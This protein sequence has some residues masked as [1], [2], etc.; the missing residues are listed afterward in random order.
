[1]AS[2]YSQHSATSGT[3]GTVHMAKSVRGGMHDPIVRMQ[4]NQANS[5]KPILIL[6]P[7][8]RGSKAKKEHSHSLTDSQSAFKGGVSWTTEDYIRAHKI[9][10][11][12]GQYNFEG[13]RIP[14]PTSIRYDRLR[15]ALGDSISPEDER[16]LDL[17]KFG[18]PIDCK[19]S[20]GRIAV[21]K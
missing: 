10:E 9:V 13:C 19:E 14:I 6:V 2:L 4:G 3:M 1:M 17:L 5:T 11:S 7:E 15:V 21:C 20:F 8:Q 12:S 18:L 16:V